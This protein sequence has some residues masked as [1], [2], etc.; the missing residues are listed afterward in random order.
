MKYALGLVLATAGVGAMTPA[1]AGDGFTVNVGSTGVGYEVGD[2]DEVV[3]LS[4]L[5]VRGGYEFN[6]FIGIE[7]E[8]SFGL[9]DDDVIVNGYEYTAEIETM[10]GAYGKLKIPVGRNVDL[11]ARAGYAN[12]SLDESLSFYRNTISN[13]E[14]HSGFA[15]G[16]GVQ[17]F[18]GGNHGV[19]VDLGGMDLGDDDGV[20]KGNVAIFSLSYAYRR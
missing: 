8:G 12:L 13:S 14:N 7:A 17:A 15:G 2:S 3:G 16:I 5:T 9:G 10:F 20:D 19:R 1:Y 18:F 11:F 4:A 6:D